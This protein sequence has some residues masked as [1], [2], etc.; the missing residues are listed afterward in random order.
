MYAHA[1]IAAVALA[2]GC[3]APF[4]DGTQGKIGVGAVSV[5]GS[6]N[7]WNLSQR[8]STLNDSNCTWWH[9]FHNTREGETDPP[10]CP[11]V[12]FLWSTAL[13][14]NSSARSV[15]V[16]QAAQS[17][18]IMTLGEWDGRS[19]TDAQACADWG[20]LVGDANIVAHPE[21]RLVGGYTVQDASAAISTC[22][23]ATEVGIDAACNHVKTWLACL[24]THGY[25]MPDALG[26]DKYGSFGTSPGANITS[27]LTRMAGYENDT[28]LKPYLFFVPEYGVLGTS[29]DNAADDIN[30][31]AVMI[32]T[33]AWFDQHPRFQH[34]AWWFMG[35][36]DCCS[37]GGT[38]RVQLYD[39][40]AARTTIGTT[41]KN[42]PRLH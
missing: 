40:S 24:T 34:Y 32:G 4:G 7:T 1:A 11:Y 26:I 33:A 29:G 37:G 28:A 3:G 9:N 19:V 16:A 15:A 14:N 22:D 2:I 30:A 41:W 13:L 12:P 31:S 38:G 36:S 39:L 21:I 25:R 6:S 18:W 8:Q 20:T 35:P 5:A 17:R 23:A 10:N 27:I 42:I